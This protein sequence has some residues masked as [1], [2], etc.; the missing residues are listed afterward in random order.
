MLIQLLM[1]VSYLR[2]D[3]GNNFFPILIEYPW[4]QVI[5][6]PIQANSRHSTR[7][8]MILSGVEGYLLYLTPSTL[9]LIQGTLRDYL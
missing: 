3:F 4:L 1:M 2:A 6:Y 5:S 8:P 9:L 7:L